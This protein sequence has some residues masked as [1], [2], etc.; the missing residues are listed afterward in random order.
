MP[1]LPGCPWLPDSSDSPFQQG[2]IIGLLSWLWDTQRPP[3]RRLREIWEYKN[4]LL[5]FWPRPACFHR[6]T[7]TASGTE[8]A[9]DHGPLRLCRAHHVFQNLIDDVLL[10]NSQITVMEQ[11]LL[12]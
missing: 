1:K 4:L 8:Y 10:K 3:S 7:D 12:G 5:C 11:I 9:F 6:G 2:P